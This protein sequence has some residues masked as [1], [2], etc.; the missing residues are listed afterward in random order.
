MNKLLLLI[1]GAFLLFSCGSRVT[2]YSWNDLE[3]L[4]LN[5][6]TQESLDSQSVKL[7]D[8]ILRLNLNAG[9]T[10]IYTSSGGIKTKTKDILAQQKLDSI[11]IF[12]VSGFDDTLRADSVILNQFFMANYPNT[13]DTLRS[14][15]DF[16]ADWGQSNDSI[17]SHFDLYLQQKPRLLSQQFAV[18]VFLNDGRVLIDTAQKV[19]FLD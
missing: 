2:V 5:H 19:I 14:V 1:V 10:D 12:S 9:I 8:F 3:I 7:E 4:N 18:E 15:D 11:H 6:V 16:V 17:E 13:T